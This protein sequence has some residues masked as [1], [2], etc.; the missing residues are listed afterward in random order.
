MTYSAGNPIQAS[1][2]NTF[3][4]AAL[5]MNQIFADLYPGATT[6]PNAGY[7]YGQT[8]AL[9]SVSIGNNVTAA[10]W[11]ALFQTI[12]KS[13][14]HQGTTVVPPLPVADPVIGGTIAAY[15]TPS[16]LATLITLLGTNR[17]N[18]AAGQSTTN[19]GTSYPQSSGAW[20]NSLTWTVRANLTTWNNARYFFNSGGFLGLNGSYS[21][22][23]T[24][25][26]AQWQSM[27]TTMSPLKFSANTTAPFSGGGGTA[28]GFYQLTTSYIQ[29]EAKLAAAAGTNGQIDF[30]VTLVDNDSSLPKDPKNGTTTYRIDETHASGAN[31][32][33]PGSVSTSASVFTSA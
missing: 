33:W 16:T 4:T 15:N 7:G 1:D 2:Y 25:E 14:T 17:F 26:D 27:F 18:L 12:R 19:I 5:G 11:T 30:R 3:A 32:A 8:P 10:Q 13:G 21:P 20:I 24:P 9:T 6:L 22:V 29:V 28:I 23:V 31:V